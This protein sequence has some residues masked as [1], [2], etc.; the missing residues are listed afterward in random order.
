MDLYRYFHPHHNPRLR[1][2]ALRLQELGELEQAALELRNALKR[3]EIRSDAAT[4]GGIRADHFSE[5]VTALDYVIESLGT[6]SDAHPG[7]ST[8]VMFEM[9]KERKD[10]PGWESWCR[11]LQQR[12][13]IT[14]PHLETRLG[15]ESQER[16]VSNE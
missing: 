14:H 13:Q 15:Q 10:A 2:H 1:S 7:D 9:L 12:L 8:E 3:A 16:K 6:L 11:L 4:V 5:L